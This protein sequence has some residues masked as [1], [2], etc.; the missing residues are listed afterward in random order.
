MKKDDLLYISVDNVSKLFFCMCAIKEIAT[1]EKIKDKK[2]ALNY[3]SNMGTEKLL[4]SINFN[5]II[6][7]LGTLDYAQEEGLLLIDKFFDY[8]T[9]KEEKEP[10]IINFKPGGGRNGSN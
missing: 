9:G 4:D 1:N 3:I 10:I 6:A 7:A 8:A 5:G 2:K